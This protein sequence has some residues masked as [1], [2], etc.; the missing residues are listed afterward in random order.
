MENVKNILAESTAKA[1]LPKTTG[2]TVYASD[3]YLPNGLCGVVLRSPYPH[4]LIHKIDT[5]KA[6]SIPG[7][8][9][10]LT[11]ED[12]PGVNRVGKTVLDQPVLASDK[13]RTMLDALVLI[14]AETLEIAKQAAAAIELDLEP[15]PAVFSVEEALKAGAPQV[16]ETGNLLRS[17][18]LERGNLAKGFR[19]ADF[20]LE[21]TYETPSIEHAYLEPDAGAACPTSNGG[22]KIWVGCH[23]VFTEQQIVGKVLDI[24]EEKIEVVQPSMGG[25]FGGKDDGLLTAYLALLAFFAQRPVRM[26]FTRREL[27]YSHTKRHPQKI[28]VRMG[29]KR[30]GEITAASYRIQ[31]D[32]GAYAHWGEGV[33]L[34]ASIGAPGPYR[35]PNV[36]VE[37]QVVYT[38]NIPMGAMRAWGMPGVTFATESHLD[39]IAKLIGIH[40]LLLRWKNA[41][42][43][44]DQL[45][46]G[47]TL[48]SGVGLKATLEAAA[49]DYGLSLET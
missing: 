40:P 41:V 5:R 28:A 24:P 13:A 9:V 2:S 25:S 33:F 49:F 16:H 36:T 12:I 48:P 11:S 39:R 14:A 27:F 23:S 18:H 38:N 20:I 31:T 22:V 34:F 17:Y 44:G 1:G 46:T 45:I 37:A 29:A 4:C 47:Q 26:V 19:E 6:K 21:D 7:V 43:E 30:N 35:I 32:T 10:I 8:G 3:I 15:L 42:E